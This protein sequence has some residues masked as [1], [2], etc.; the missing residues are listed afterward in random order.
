MYG[1]IRM[2][3]VKKST[4]TNDMFSKENAILRTSAISKQSSLFAKN[5]TFV[6]SDEMILNTHIDVG[7][8]DWRYSNTVLLCVWYGHTFDEDQ[9]LDH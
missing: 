8:K 6:V 4:R 5:D 7:A 9:R 3:L 1:F 2:V